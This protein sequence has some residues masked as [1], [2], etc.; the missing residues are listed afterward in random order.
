MIERLAPGTRTRIGP[1]RILGLLGAG[2]MGE[3]YL[4][5]PAGEPAGGL[6]ALKTVRAELDLDDGFRV[7]F[8]RETEAAAA[9]RSPRTAAFVGG[10]STGRIPWLATEYVPGP[11]LAEA[12]ARG[13][14]LPEQ[15]VRAMGAGLALA[16]ADMHAV[17]VL[18][19]DLKPGNVLL[20]PDGPKVIDFG[21]AQAFD[22]T[23]LTRTGVV[24]GSP[25]YISPEHVN[26][27]SALVPASDVFCLGAVLAFAAAGRGPFDDSDMAAV[28]FRI[29]RGEAELSGVPSPLREVITRCLDTRPEERPA[30]RELAALLL[31]EQPSVPF[32]WTPGVR[33]Q[34]A[35]HERAARECADS[36]P[37][38]PAPEPA[39]PPLPPRPPLAAAT[40]PGAGTDAPAGR[41]RTLQVVL[42]ALAVTVCLLLGHALW[43]DP[44]PRGGDPGGG[45]RSTGPGAGPSHAAGAVGV[46]ALPR[47]DSGRTGDFGK[48]ATDQSVRPAG[49]K[50]WQAT[51][52]GAAG[53]C[54]LA[55]SALL[56]GGSKGVTALDAA[57]GEQRWRTPEGAQGATAAVVAGFTK[58]TVYAFVGHALVGYRITDGREQWRAK[59]PAGHTGSAAV[60]DGTTLYYV[61]RG[62]TPATG[63]LAARRLTG[64]RGELWN[65]P[66]AGTRPTLVADDGRL[67]VVAGDTRILDGPTGTVQEQLSANDFPCR[68]PALKGR[69]LVCR[70]VG[71]GVAV[72]NDVTRPR[73]HRII[74]EGIAVRYPVVLTD[75]GTVVVDSDD[76]LHA[77]DVADGRPKWS[78]NPVYRGGIPSVAG[79]R[80][81]AARGSG[82]GTYRRTDGEPTNTTGYTGVPY[83]PEGPPQLLAVGDV[84]FL[85]FDD[86]TVVSGYVP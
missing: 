6:V 46:R 33:A 74:A 21:I 68:D 39:V 28:I 43:P 79:D 38:E 56:C 20:G 36:A 61:T 72:M 76:R 1:Y 52:E 2:G 7:R 26:G 4:A 31:P 32:P 49:W 14:P 30:P 80:I 5:R 58:G 82:V 53:G 48:A 34:Q 54:S 19:R 27:S 11:S 13:G 41:R 70:A 51:V 50:A 84:V 67:V 60:Q 42:V 81:L 69:L 24:V 22:A 71:R 73:A 47:A 63:R 57:D 25:G 16:L 10:D 64:D 29:A 65:K 35:E 44:A 8:R 12:V 17:R 23:Q 83:P 3:V 40:A 55:E 75:D 59:L 62:G 15:V 78:G 86:G 18:H 37:A 9:V 45:A 66:Y 85:T 77:F